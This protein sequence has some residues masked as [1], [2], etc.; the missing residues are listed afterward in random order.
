MGSVNEIG[1]H[2]GGGVEVM[3][4]RVVTA[5]DGKGL[6]DYQADQSMPS[7]QRFF[8]ALEEEEEASTTSADNTS[9]TANHTPFAHRSL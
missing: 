5:D 1:A 7:R 9:M 4:D 2:G 6:G 8:L 3:V